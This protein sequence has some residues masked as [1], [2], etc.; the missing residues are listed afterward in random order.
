MEEPRKKIFFF[1]GL[2]IVPL[3]H[4]YHEEFAGFPSSLFYANS[5]RRTWPFKRS[6]FG[7]QFAFKFKVHDSIYLL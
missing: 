3:Q 5:M 7:L 1:Q 2:D 6:C 4:K